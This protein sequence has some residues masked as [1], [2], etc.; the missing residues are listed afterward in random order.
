MQKEV[1]DMMGNI[2]R[3]NAIPKRIV[4]VVPSQTEF[5]YELGLESEVVG[6]TKF[7]I[8]PQ[9]WFNSKTRVGGTKQ[10]N[11]EK[12]LSLQ[13]DIVI[14]NKEENTK[15]DIEALQEYVPVWLSD[16]YTLDDAF[17]MMQHLGD[18]L[19]K[20]EA[21]R[22][23]I[24]NIQNHFE[25]IPSIFQQQ[26]VAYLIWKA[27]YMVAAKDTFIHDIIQRL[28][29]INA[30]QH[31]SRYPEVTLS[32]LQSADIICLSSEPYPFKDKHVAELQLEFPDKKII[33]LDGEMFSWYGSRLKHWKTY[34]HELFSLL[35]K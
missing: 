29:G 31:C 10:L 18:L 25:I 3:L 22:T 4:S 6:I 26:K 17:I 1:K 34:Y 14:A 2:I 13:P 15:A 27:P 12:I 28:D 23:I 9:Q 33:I 5:L 16:I 7:C 24:Q 19:D 32:D 35:H 20:P 30:F 8:H 21:A 11:I